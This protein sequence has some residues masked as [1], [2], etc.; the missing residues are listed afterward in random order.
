MALRARRARSCRLF[1]LGLRPILFL[2]GLPF[3]ALLL[4]FRSQWSALTPQLAE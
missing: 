3:Q 2:F 1:G 4:L